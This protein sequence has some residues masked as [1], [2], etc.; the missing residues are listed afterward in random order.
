M[1]IA[2]VIGIV[3]IAIKLMNKKISQELD[4][5]S[6]GSD[7]STSSCSTTTDFETVN[8]KTSP[9]KSNVIQNGTY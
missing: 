1:L 9:N 2:G 3:A 7:L 5:V 6:M 8:E 4:N